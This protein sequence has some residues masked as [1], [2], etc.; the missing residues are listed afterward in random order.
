[1]AG[2]AEDDEPLLIDQAALTGES[3]PV[4][5]FAGQV[6]FSGSIVK[7]GESKALVYG[8]GANTFFG[9]A[10]ALIASSGDQ[11]GHLQQVMTTIGFS[12]V[13]TILLWVVIELAVQF[14]VYKHQCLPGEGGQPLLQPPPPP[15]HCALGQPANGHA[16]LWMAALP[17]PG[18]CPS[19]GTHSRQEC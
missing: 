4:K 12:C 6:G 1:M 17:Q 9:K 16:R 3:L 18:L 2:N 19:G 10:A 15:D 5:R 11:A 14:G 13:A 7:Q 8:T